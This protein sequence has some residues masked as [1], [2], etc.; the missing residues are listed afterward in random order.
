MNDRTDPLTEARMGADRLRNIISE[1]YINGSTEI[2][3]AIDAAILKVDGNKAK[4]DRKTV[5]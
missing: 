2:K 1:T 3:K 4:I 5:L